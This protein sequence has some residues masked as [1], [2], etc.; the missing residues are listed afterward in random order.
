M[1]EDRSQDQIE[2]FY[3][4]DALRGIAAI[5]IVIFHYHHFYLADAFDRLSIPPIEAFPYA[6]ILAPLYNPFAANAVELFWLISGFVFSHVYLP[7]HVDAWVF[8]VARFARLYPLHFATL[9][10]VAALQAISLNFVGHWQIYANNDIEH[11]LLQLLM[12]S[13]WITW[14]RG[15]SFNGPI[16]SVSLEIFV[17]GLF[18]LS[19]FVMRRTPIVVSLV[20]CAASW[21]WLAFELTRPPL[22]RLGVFECAGYFFL[23]TLLYTL[24][25]DKNLLRCAALTAIGMLVSTAGAMVDLERMVIAGAAVAVLSLAAGLDRVAPASGARLSGLGD[26]SYSVYL[27]HVPLQMTVLLVADLAFGGARGFSDS[28]LTLPIYLTTTVAVSFIAYR[29]FERPV[30]KAIKVGLLH[31]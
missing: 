13:N 24:R 27:V 22:I 11:F 7:R 17:Y 31:R 3:W 8:G 18:F 21:G 1:S 9:L 6:D 16:W 26:I 15:L 5:S 10:Y 30:G 14:S 20:L 2:R 28:H 23:G 4:I 12:S 25:P 19:L 29:W